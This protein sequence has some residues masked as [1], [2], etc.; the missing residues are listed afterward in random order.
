[1]TRQDLFLIL[2]LLFVFLLLTHFDIRF[3]TFCIVLF[4]AQYLRLL[5]D[6]INMEIRGRFRRQIQDKKV[7][8]KRQANRQY[9]QKNLFDT[10]QN[11]KY[12]TV[13]SP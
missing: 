4:L 9:T 12:Y 6:R 10:F 2:S 8:D 11:A 7:I 1:M 3:I 13:V 5:V